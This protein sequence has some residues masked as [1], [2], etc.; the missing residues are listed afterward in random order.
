MKEEGVWKD[1]GSAGSGR[2]GLAGKPSKERSKSAHR[3]Q[4]HPQRVLWCSGRGAWVPG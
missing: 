1:L 3:A 4:S 2:K